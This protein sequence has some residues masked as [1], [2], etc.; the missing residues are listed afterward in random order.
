MQ[1]LPGIDQPGVLPREGTGFREAVNPGKYTVCSVFQ[2]IFPHRI[3][4]QFQCPVEGR[5]ASGACSRG[6]PGLFTFL[7][8]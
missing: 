8:R 1:D 4:K 2:K 6:L 5:A 3:I 7:C